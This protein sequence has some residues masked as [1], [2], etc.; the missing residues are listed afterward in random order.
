MSDLKLSKVSFHSLR[1]RF[2]TN[3][4]EL[5]FDVKTLSEILGHSSVEITL[6][7]YVHSSM[8]RKAQCMRSLSSIFTVA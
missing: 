4:I 7:R 5:G 2:A 8:E 6:N 1:H 3:C